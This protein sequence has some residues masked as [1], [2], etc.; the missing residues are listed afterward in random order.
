M[1]IGIARVK[2]ICT[3]V[4]K[5]FPYDSLWLKEKI[6]YRGILKDSQNALKNEVRL[7]EIHQELN[8]MNRKLRE[9]RD[10]YSPFYNNPFEFYRELI[11]AV[12]KHKIQNCGELSRIAYAI[13]RMNG[14]GNSNLDLATFTTKEYKD[15]SKSLFPE[16]DKYLDLM[17]EMEDGGDY[18]IIDHAALQIHGKKKKEFILDPLLNEC[19]NKVEAERIYKTQYGDILN[20]TSDEN[21]QIVNGYSSCSNLPRLNKDEAKE[22]LSL[23]PEL[24]I[25]KK[26]EINS[27]KKF[28]FFEWIEAIQKQIS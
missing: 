22:L 24:K 8:D 3:T 18:R 10:A 5:N 25:G 9:V 11:K 28:F 20:I 1:E 12:H 26:M 2:D 15:Y 23:Y 19:H 7:G 14:I 21:L 17:L 13:A 27:R 4:R 6:Q 16:I